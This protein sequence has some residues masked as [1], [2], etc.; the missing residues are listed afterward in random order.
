MLTPDPVTCELVLAAIYPGVAVS[1]VRA[2]T[3]WD[4]RVAADLHVLPAPAL[5]ELTA[6]RR[7]IATMPAAKTPAPEGAAR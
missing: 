7:L 2:R 5:D 3:G 1:D 6:L 4:L